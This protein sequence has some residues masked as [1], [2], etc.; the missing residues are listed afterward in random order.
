MKPK[1][2][3]RIPLHTESTRIRADLSG[4][5]SLR[6]PQPLTAKQQSGVTKWRD[7]LEC[8]CKSGFP[9]LS[10][11]MLRPKVWIGYCKKCKPK[12]YLPPAEGRLICD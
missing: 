2:T 1:P 4:Y 10:R 7:S 9:I 11:Q 5:Y 6:K 8:K 3:D 12:P